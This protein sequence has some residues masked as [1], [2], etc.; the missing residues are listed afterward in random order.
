MPGRYLTEIAYDE[1]HSLDDVIHQVRRLV[2]VPSNAPD[3]VIEDFD[4]ADRPLIEMTDGTIYR[5]QRLTD[6]GDAA[7]VDLLA[8]LRRGGGTPDHPGL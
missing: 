1:E 4:P 2:E 8:E 5:D 3:A 7:V 6:A